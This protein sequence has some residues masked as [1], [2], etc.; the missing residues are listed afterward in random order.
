MSSIEPK[1]LKALLTLL[2]DQDDEVYQHVQERLQGYGMEVLPQLMEAWETTPNLLLQDRIEFVIH[3]IQLNESLTEFAE[4]LR[5]PDLD[6]LTGALI[7]A[8]H[9]YPDFNEHLIWNR[10]D[11]LK[12][13]IWVEMRGFTSPIEKVNLFNHVFYRQWEF[14][15]K[16]IEEDEEGQYFFINRVIESRK[17]ND[18]TLGILYLAMAKQLGLP[19]YGVI[20]PDNFCLAFCKKPLD[21]EHLPTDPE[22]LQRGIQFF[23]NPANKGLIFTRHELREHLTKVNQADL[24]DKVTPVS[25]LQVIELLLRALQAHYERQLKPQQAEDMEAYLSLLS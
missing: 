20:L 9:R 5:T 1:E 3:H 14:T 13:D 15:S 10:I 7:I 17:G 4:W 2:D 8:K 12:R 21:E 22:E 24:Y 25:T 11:Q 19:V 23:I 18:L 16:A 6:L